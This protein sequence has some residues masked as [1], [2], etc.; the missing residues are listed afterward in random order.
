MQILSNGGIGFDQS[1]RTYKASVLP[2]EGL[3]LIAPFWN[4]NDLRNGGN[5]YYREVTSKKKKKELNRQL[6]N[7]IVSEGRVLERGQAE[8]RFQYDKNL[9]VVSALL[10]TWE[11]MQPL[12]AAALPDEV[13]GFFTSILL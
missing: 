6:S 3:K 13:G 1:S 10:V 4:R 7:L 8:I 12:G 2:S 9:K 11:K 5:V